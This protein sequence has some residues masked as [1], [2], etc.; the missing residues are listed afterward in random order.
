M[1]T[2]E[3]LLQGSRGRKEI[4][5]IRDKIRR[6][7]IL[8]PGQNATLMFL[9]QTPGH[10]YP[11]KIWSQG[12]PDFAHLEQAGIP[13]TWM[14][15]VGDCSGRYQCWTEDGVDL[16]CY[17]VF[18]S[19]YDLAKKR[20]W[21]RASA[22][23]ELLL[24]EAD[25]PT[26]EFI[27]AL[28]EFCRLH[29]RLKWEVNEQPGHPET[30]R[31]VAWL[32]DVYEVAACFLDAQLKSPEQPTEAAVGDGKANRRRLEKNIRPLPTVANELRAKPFYAPD[33]K[34]LVAMSELKA[35][36]Q[37]SLKPAS[38]IGEKMSPSKTALE[39]KDGL[40]RLRNG[41]FVK[42]LSHGN[43][44]GYW[45]TAKG[46]KKLPSAKARRKHS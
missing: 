6:D 26:S 1:N 30:R 33:S 46:R 18:F 11:L 10:P 5:T 32:N 17:D 40:R 37:E 31:R 44:G 2:G 36:D 43:Q 38:R 21:Q 25:I 8:M 13:P 29:K 9:A 28:F 27:K 41:G 39:L 22:C 16:A 7:R 23:G 45:L 3:T 34:I 15:P 35:D 20:F 19:G 14:K 42:S 12:I 24:P 4:E